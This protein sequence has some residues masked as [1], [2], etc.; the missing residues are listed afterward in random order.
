MARGEKLIVERAEQGLARAFVLARRDGD[1]PCFHLSEPSCE[2][3]GL[4]DDEGAAYPVG[5]SRVKLL[6]HD[7][8]PSADL[9]GRHPVQILLATVRI[10]EFPAEPTV[11]ASSQSLREL[12]CCH[13]AGHQELLRSTPADSAIALIS[14]DAFSLPHPDSTARSMNTRAAS[15][16]VTGVCRSPANRCIRAASFCM[17]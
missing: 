9:R 3:A 12:I 11:A 5:Q 2:L 14:A 7:T 1:N 6:T 16:P 10:H 13:P 15:T 4:P 8:P 17:R